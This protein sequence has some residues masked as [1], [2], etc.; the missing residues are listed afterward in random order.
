MSAIATGVLAALLVQA[1]P[2]GTRRAVATLGALGVAGIVAVLFLEDLLWPHLGQSTLLLLVGSAASLLIATTWRERL[3]PTRPRVWLDWLRSF[4]R[5]SYE[6]YLT[7]MF[8]VMTV[9]G[10]WR[11]HGGDLRLGFLW[12][13]TTLPVCW[14]LGRAWERLVSG[15][16]NRTLRARLLD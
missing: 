16:W 6:V 5:L 1:K 10:L 3:A 14:G 15:P 8:V 11:A 12:Y 13:L 9:V 7:H 2:T 4:G